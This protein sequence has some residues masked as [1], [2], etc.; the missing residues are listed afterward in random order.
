M[1]QHE[2]DGLCAAMLSADSGHAFRRARQQLERHERHE[3]VQGLIRSMRRATN[4]KVFDRAA[5]L[6]AELGGDTAAEALAIEARA[7]RQY[8]RLAIRA[9]ARCQH[10]AVVPVLLD[11]LESGRM[12][13][14]RAAA[15]ALARVRSPF[16]VEPLC[17][18]AAGGDRGI[19]P[20]ATEAL[21]SFGSPRH[22]ARLVLGETTYQAADHVRVL[23]AVSASPLRDG[24][25][26][27][28]PFDGKRYLEREAQA[29]SSP[30]QAQAREAADLLHKQSTLLRGA[31][32][33]NTDILLRAA[34][35]PGNAAAD[36]LL[37]PSDWASPAP[38]VARSRVGFWLRFVVAARSMILRILRILRILGRT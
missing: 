2:L 13:Q 1:E 35:T 6:L 19:G 18:A 38:G 10:P 37:R 20:E 17:R 26:R 14:R 27:A 29:L 12:K 3:T 31:T 4:Q 24:F 11:L 34:S 32:D 30:V 25:W 33:V 8:P 16:A 15:F 28:A 36:S 22:V 9:L 5:K 7:Q 23:L 21:R